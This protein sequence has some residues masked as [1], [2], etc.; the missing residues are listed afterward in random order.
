M[1]ARVCITVAWTEGQQVPAEDPNTVRID[2]G[3]RVKMRTVQTPRAVVWLLNGTPED[4]AKAEAWA[5][6]QPGH[7]VETWPVGIADP[8]GAAKVKVIAS[9]VSA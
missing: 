1:G 9:P 6:T 5:A 4:V 8:L 7:V 2:L 3:V